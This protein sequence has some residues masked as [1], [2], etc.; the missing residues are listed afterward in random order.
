MV[1]DWDN[2]MCIKFSDLIFWFCKIYCD[3]V[4]D[5]LFLLNFY[6]LKCYC[7]ELLI[8]YYDFKWFMVIFIYILIVYYNIYR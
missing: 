6:D 7:C 4:V 3:F 5:K 2:W 1:K 8:E